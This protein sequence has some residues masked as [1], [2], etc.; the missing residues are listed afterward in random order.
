MPAPADAHADST[1]AAPTGPTERL[2]WTRLG[3]ALIVAAALAGGAFVGVQRAITGHAPRAKSWNVPY[4]DVTLS[5]TYQFQ[6]PRS[7]PARDVALAFVVADPEDPCQPSWGGYYDLDEAGAQLELDRRIDQLRSAGGDVVISFGG[8]ANRELAVACADQTALVRAYRSVIDRYAATTIDLDIEGPALS[9]GESITRRAKALSVV[10]DEIESDGGRLDVWLT[11]PVTPQ[12]LTSDGLGVVEETMKAGLDVLGVN[13]MTMN[14]GD[15]EEPRPDMLELSKDAVDATAAQMQQLYLRLDM[16]VS[17]TERW[18]AIGATPMI[19]QNDVAG[20]VFTVADAEAFVAFARDR[21]L[22]RVSTWSLNRDHDCG[23]TFSDVAVLSNTCSGVDQQ[24][25]EFSKIFSSLPG[26][27]PAAP[28][29]DSVTVPDR[30]PTDE[31][32]TNT[33][34][35]VWRSTAQYPQGYKVVWKGHVYQ[36]KWFNEGIDPS[37]DTAKE[38]ETPWA[39][40]GPVRPEDTAPTITTVPPGTHPDWDPTTL[41]EKGVTVAFDGLPYRSRWSTKGDAP[42]TQ[43]PVGADSPW[44]PLFDVPGA[45]SSD[46]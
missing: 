2:S 11:L 8:Q 31:D 7:N 41:Y 16:T 25:L 6:D 3:I 39:L 27:A 38:W 30:R 10:Q 12:G 40:V 5:P 29:V 45:P 13:V 19:G 35:P 22:G 28:A 26:R 23:A 34:F 32:P 37:I 33:P 24:S 44:E 36:A 15:A 14:Y 46:S 17:D 20:E 43:F 1:P 4:V 18:A 42:V 9:D 21:G